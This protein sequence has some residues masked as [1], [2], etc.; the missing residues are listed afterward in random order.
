VSSDRN[1]LHD[2]AIDIGGLLFE[3]R[4]ALAAV[5]SGIEMLERRSAEPPIAAEL[6]TLAKLTD[7]ACEAL[8]LL[9]RAIIS[10]LGTDE[11]A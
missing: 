1:K 3:C 10:G 9:Q 2:V 7:Q 6:E 5:S 4:I 11:I 8:E